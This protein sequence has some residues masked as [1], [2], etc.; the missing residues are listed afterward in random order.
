MDFTPTINYLTDRVAALNSA[1]E[2]LKMLQAEGASLAPPITPDPE[3]IWKKPTGKSKMALPSPKKVKASIA[4][5]KHDAI[6]SYLQN[7]PGSGSVEIAKALRFSRAATTWNLAKAKKSGLVRMDG[8]TAN[9]K[10]SLVK[11]DAAAKTPA[12]IAPGPETKLECI[13]CHAPFKTLALLESHMRVVHGKN[14]I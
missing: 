11:Q 3:P 12:A 5:S 9:T 8:N 10:Y 4:G 2:T 6:L 1:I 14:S 7:H 13:F